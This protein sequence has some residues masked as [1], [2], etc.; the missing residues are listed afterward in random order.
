MSIL[1]PKTG[2]LQMGPENKTDIFSKTAQTILIKFQKFMN[3]T[4]LK[5]GGI[6]RK[7]TVHTIGAQTQNSRL[8]SIQ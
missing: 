3:I 6:F 5:I 1:A 7:I 4:S 8:F 2:T